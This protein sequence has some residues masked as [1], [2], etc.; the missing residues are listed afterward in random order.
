MGSTST[1]GYTGSGRSPAASQRR[2]SGP[3]SGPRVVLA[4]LDT[5]HLGFR[6]PEARPHLRQLRALVEDTAAKPKGERLLRLSDGSEWVVGGGTKFHVGSLERGGIKVLVTRDGLP[7]NPELSVEVGS[8]ACHELGPAGA[9]RRAEG[10]AHEL[11][12]RPPRSAVLSRVDPCVDV[13]G[14]DLGRTDQDEWVTR[15]RAAKVRGTEAE[16]EVDWQRWRSGSA[17]N[18]IRWGSRT[19]GLM[20]RA[21]DKIREMREQSNKVWF[22]DMWAR[23]NGGEPPTGVWRVEAELRRTALRGDWWPRQ[24]GPALPVD[25]LSGLERALPAIWR[26]LM[27]SRL[28]WTVPAGA[29]RA[30]WELRDEWRLIADLDWSKWGFAAAEGDH[31]PAAQAKTDYAS[32]LPILRGLA[33]RAGALRG[34]DDLAEAFGVILRDVVALDLELGRDATAEMREFLAQAAPAAAPESVGAVA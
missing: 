28:R 24:E 16:D 15:L 12:D 31:V 25:T 5:L 17:V 1:V 21:Y 29:N 14:L 19:S 10:L 32:L 30:R 13:A 11:F 34:L 7:K 27:G 26:D 18:S 9:W 4:G 3:C 2:G 22:W 33:V 20:V 6:C 8:R 23:H